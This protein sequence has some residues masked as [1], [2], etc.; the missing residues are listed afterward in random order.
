MAGAPWAYFDEIAMDR[1]SRSL[2]AGQIVRLETPERAVLG[3]AAFNPGS[4]IAAR[5]LDPNPDAAIDQAWF[6]NR[7]ARA[8]A[9][10]QTLFQAP[11]YRLIHAE[12][13]GLPGVIV[14]QYGTAA[15]IQPNAA[16]ADARIDALAEAV[17]A[18]T[19][20][21]TLILN[22]QS[23]ARR[24][25]GLE[26]RTD[27]FKGQA[28]APMPVRMNGA[29]YLADLTGGQ[30][31]GLFL[32]QR[33]NH[34]FAAQLGQGGRVLDLFAHVGGFGLAALAGGA[35]EGLAVDSS[36]A[37]LDLAEAGARATGVADR[38]TTRRADAFD[39]LRD[40]ATEGQRFD[41]VIC[42]PPAFAP[43]RE[44]LSGG[45]RAYERLARAAC[46][47]VAP[48]GFLVLC[49]CSHAADLARFRSASLGGVARAER[50]ARILATGEA[51]PD[52]PVHPALA[53][54]SYLKALFLALD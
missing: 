5:L 28:D 21:E 51:G 18:V 48:S 2:P 14:D 35:A 15:V 37:A 16:W 44:A 41:L 47:V 12:A 13:D 4:K 50:T 36:A 1:R 34:A 23:R 33:A 53:E 17:L 49:S 52:H 38:Y 20:V 11:P 46:R 30:K 25:E 40:L 31:T 27:L 39:A 7:L 19:Q 42:D 32:D 45:L 29:T 43:S 54:T 6:A 3:T 26:T 8:Q 22:G 9:L 24:L 10:R